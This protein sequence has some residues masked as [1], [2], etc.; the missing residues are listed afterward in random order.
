MATVV[1]GPTPRRRIPA[2]GSRAISTG[3]PSKTHGQLER[4][5]GRFS[6]RRLD[7]TDARWKGWRKRRRTAAPRPHERWPTGRRDRTRRRPRSSRPPRRMRNSP[8]PRCRSDLGRLGRPPSR[9]RLRRALS[10]PAFTC[11]SPAHG[12]AARRADSGTTEPS[13][14]DRPPPVPPCRPPNVDGRRCAARLVAGEQAR[15]PPRRRLIV[16]RSVTAP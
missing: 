4:G 12:A 13:G 14:D 5:R 16:R 7:P 9:R 1:P 3:G 10:G 2:G 8:R 6:R 15:V 11:R